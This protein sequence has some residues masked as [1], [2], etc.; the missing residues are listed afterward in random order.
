MQH[1]HSGQLETVCDEPS[2][3]TSYRKPV[4]RVGPNR[5]FRACLRSRTR[6]EDEQIDGQEQTHRRTDRQTDTDGLVTSQFRGVGEGFE[7]PHFWLTF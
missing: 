2:T 3:P 5:L 4:R 1:G 6:T 7:E